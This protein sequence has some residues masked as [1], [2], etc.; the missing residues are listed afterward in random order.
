MA[1]SVQVLMILCCI[2]GALGQNKCL[3][4]PGCDC[5]LYMIR[6]RST[7]TFPGALSLLTH[8]INRHLVTSADMKHCFILA[9]RLS[10]FLRAFQH[11]LQKVDIRNALNDYDCAKILTIM[12]AYP[13]M[14]LLSDCSTE[15][16]TIPGEDN[17]F[18]NLKKKKKMKKT[19]IYA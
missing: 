8:P 14:T 15:K 10:A 12:T 17:F 7:R 18:F 19:L 16:R 2:F 5:N 9:A 11:S 13:E 6:C 4:A 1:I 3:D